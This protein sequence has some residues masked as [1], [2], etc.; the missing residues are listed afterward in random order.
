MSPILCDYCEAPASMFF[1]RRGPGERSFTCAE[2][3]ERAKNAIGMHADKVGGILP[4]RPRF[5]EL[6]LVA[7]LARWR[8]HRHAAT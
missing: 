1:P 5:E 8:E 7:M 4:S 2:H 3:E 6:D